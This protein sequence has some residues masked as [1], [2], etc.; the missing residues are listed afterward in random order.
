MDDE[1]RQRKIDGYNERLKRTGTP[2]PSTRIRIE[3]GK[4]FQVVQLAEAQMAKALGA[5]A[6]P[7]EVAR[8]FRRLLGEAETRCAEIHADRITRLETENN[9]LKAETARV[10]RESGK[11]S[12]EWSLERRDM[13]QKIESLERLYEAA[14]ARLR[15][16]ADG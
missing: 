12:F 9:E 2:P 14:K 8:T 16:M 13:V 6:L 7:E 15:K 11:Q 5:E 10:I 3:T 1:E 4:L